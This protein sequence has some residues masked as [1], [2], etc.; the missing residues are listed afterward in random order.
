MTAVPLRCQERQCERDAA[1]YLLPCAHLAL[2]GPCVALFMG[3]RCSNTDCNHSTFNGIC[4]LNS[5]ADSI[6]HNFASTSVQSSSF[7]EHQLLAGY[8]YE[9]SSSSLQNRSHHHHPHHHPHPSRLL[10]CLFIYPYTPILGG[11]SAGIL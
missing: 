1:F 6:R 11:T 9:S 10:S 8:N 5:V 3:K 7:K 2:C 4:A